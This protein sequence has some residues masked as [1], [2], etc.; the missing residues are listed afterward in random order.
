MKRHAA[1]MFMGAVGRRALNVCGA[2]RS[3]NRGRQ[4]VVT[5]IAGSADVRFRSRR[6]PS[7][8]GHECRL[9]LGLLPCGL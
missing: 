1:I 2:G 9:K 8:T 6:G 5:F 3:L 4:V 7:L